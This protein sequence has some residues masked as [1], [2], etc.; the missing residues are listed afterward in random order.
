ME[1]IR[2]VRD[3]QRT[4]QRLRAR[5]KTIGLV[6]T[7]GALHEGH[8][9]LIDRARS[10]CDVLVTSIYVNPAQFGAGEDFNT[11]PRTFDADCALARAHGCDIVFAPTD[12]EM[13]PPGYATYVVLDHP[14]TQR[15]CGRAR[16]GHFR[17]VATIVTKLFTS[18]MPSCAVFGQKD[19]QQALVLNRMV[20][21]LHLPVTLDV[22][23]I[24]R[25]KDGLALSSRNSYLTPQE[26][27]EVPAIY[28]GLQR[29]YRLWQQGERR[30]DTLRHEIVSYYERFSLFDT[31]YAEIVDTETLDPVHTTD[32]APFLMAVACRT[33]RT[34]TRLIDN[35]VCNGDL[36]D[37]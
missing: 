36:L 26:R 17:G 21:D 8:L 18:V 22:A 35:M 6:P 4:A 32:D 13:Y 27:A 29:A 7:M 28:Q 15:L 24:V 25:E 19:A 23:P 37:F 20:Q 34:H 9:S 14:L 10:H 31:E 1:V 2:T 33:T 5:E 30:G 16:P 12:A 3:M 11:Y